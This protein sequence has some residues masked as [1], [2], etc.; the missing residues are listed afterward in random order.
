MIASSK[1]EDIDIDVSDVDELDAVD[2]DAENVLE[3]DFEKLK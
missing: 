2:L 1:K 3:I